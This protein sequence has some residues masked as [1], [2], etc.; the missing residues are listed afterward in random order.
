MDIRM[1]G[2]D[3]LEAT[4]R[5][6][7]FKPGCGCRIIIL[8]TFDLDESV[9]AALTGPNVTSCTPVTAHRRTRHRPRGHISL[10]QAIE[11]Q[12]SAVCP[13]LGW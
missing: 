8:T 1:P 9:C 11:D 3:G 4:R 12:L 2:M 10:P 7:G 5:I 6:L 13:F